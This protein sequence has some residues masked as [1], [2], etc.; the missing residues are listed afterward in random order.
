MLWLRHDR[1]VVSGVASHPCDAVH[2]R[3]TNLARVRAAFAGAGGRV[4]SDHA[5]RRKQNQPVKE[6]HGRFRTVVAW[7]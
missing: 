1:S 2:A 4:A 7:P 3:H 6:G 5:G